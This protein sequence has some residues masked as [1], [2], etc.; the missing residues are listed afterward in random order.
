L[1]G[2]S[3]PPGRDQAFVDL[4]HNPA[5]VMNAVADIV[6]QVSNFQASQANSFQGRREFSP[7]GVK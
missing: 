6:S 3:L 2:F 1:Q 5:G 7:Q 4:L